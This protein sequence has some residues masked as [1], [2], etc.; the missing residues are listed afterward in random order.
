MSDAVAR[1][2]LDEARFGIRVA[3]GAPADASQWREALAF[4]AANDVRLLIARIDAAQTRLAQCMEDDGAR[5]ADVLLQFRATPTQRPAP[6]RAGGVGVRVCAPGDAGR[7]A[8]LARACFEGYAS[9]YRADPHLDPRA[10]DE[11]Y[12]D[13]ARRACAD[14]AVADAVI[15][16]ERGHEWLGFAALRMLEPQVADGMLFGVAPAARG[17]GILG[18]LLDEFLAWAV[19]QGAASAIY[20]TQ[21]ANVAA[22]KR[23]VRAGFVPDRAFLTFHLWLPP[24]G[25]PGQR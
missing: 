2:P 19:R 22:Q 17:Q 15:V 10:C 24:G 21:L 5:M 4:C 8:D 23:V 25:R 11:V 7:V 3:K 6:G 13:W 12:A 18:D 9:H 20:Q 16:A 1:S 14:P